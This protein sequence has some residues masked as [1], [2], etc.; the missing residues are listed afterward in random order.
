MLKNSKKLFSPKGAA[1]GSLTGLL[2]G[3]AFMVGQMIYPP[4]KGLPPVSMSGCS[5]NITITELLTTDN[6]DPVNQ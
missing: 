1:V 2:V 4:S 6:K 5:S 3:I